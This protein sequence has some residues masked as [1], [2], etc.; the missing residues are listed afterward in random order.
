MTPG[1]IWD[2]EA[3]YATG[4]SCSRTGRNC[5]MPTQTA[6]WI[7]LNRIPA[8]VDLTGIGLCV[9]GAGRC[10]PSCI[11][12]P[13]CKLPWISASRHLG[14]NIFFIFFLYKKID[15]YSILFSGSSTYQT[16]D[17]IGEDQKSYHTTTSLEILSTFCI[18]KVINC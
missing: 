12:G 16:K 11:R 14:K 6:V 9:C 5:R 1:V 18:Y 3:V 4:C 13:G 7:P 15:N 8:K 17:E 2:P 10:T